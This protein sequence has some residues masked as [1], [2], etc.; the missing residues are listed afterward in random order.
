MDPK[1]FVQDFADYINQVKTAIVSLPFKDGGHKT[2]KKPKASHDITCCT[3]ILQNQSDKLTSNS[4]S[5]II[6]LPTKHF[7]IFRKTPCLKLRFSN[8][9][10]PKKQQNVQGVCFGRN[11]EGFMVKSSG[12][13]PSPSSSTITG[14]HFA[15]KCDLICENAH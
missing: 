7:E 15:A 3:S 13:Q 6:N 4:E 2:H 5:S 12:F 14:R 8:L 1:P 11:Q 10:Q 9:G